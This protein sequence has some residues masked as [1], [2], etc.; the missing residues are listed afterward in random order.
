MNPEVRDGHFTTGEEGGNSR[1]KAGKDERA[2]NQ[3]N[4]ASDQASRG[5]NLDG[6]A[7]HR[8]ERLLSTDHH[9]V[10]V[11]NYEQLLYSDFTVVP[12]GMLVLD[13]IH[14]VKNFTAATSRI[15]LRERRAV[16]HWR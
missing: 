1:E 8:R 14:K 5:V 3:L 16:A 13:E 11:A 4:C 12:W 7:E 9:G 10:L 2:S 6:S 15:G